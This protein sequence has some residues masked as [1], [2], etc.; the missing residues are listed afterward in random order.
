MLARAVNLNFI[1]GTREAFIFPKFFTKNTFQYWTG[2]DFFLA[3]FLR[4]QNLY[5]DA[6]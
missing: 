1:R 2:L 5:K 3:F 4:A 6:S